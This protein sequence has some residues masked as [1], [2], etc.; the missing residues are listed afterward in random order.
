MRTRCTVL[1]VVALLLA[2]LPAV[3]APQRAEPEAGTSWFDAFLLH[4]TEPISRLF[5]ASEE[6]LGPGIDPGELESPPPPPID[7]DKGPGV[8]PDG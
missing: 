1:L 5:G 7:E 8:D 4:L 2:P 6:D 3:A